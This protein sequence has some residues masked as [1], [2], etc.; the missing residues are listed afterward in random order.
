[1][2]NLMRDVVN[3]HKATDTPVLH[4]PG[5]PIADR[6]E[7]RISLLQEELDEFIDAAQKRNITEVADALA[8]IIYVAVGAALE[9]G[10]PLADVWAEVQASNMMKCDLKTGKVVRRKDG[11]ILKPDGWKPPDIESIIQKAQIKES[12]S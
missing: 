5:F 7:L 2:I 6:V 3:F 9:F 4:K 11:K 12:S 1:M 8:D 10:I